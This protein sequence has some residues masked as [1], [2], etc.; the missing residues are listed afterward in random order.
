MLLKDGRQIDPIGRRFRRIV[1][2]R[3]QHVL[4]QAAGVG[5]DA[6]QDTRMKRMEKIAVAQKK[7]DHFRASFEHPAGLRIGTKSETPDRLKHP[8]RALPR[9]WSSSLLELLPLQ[10][11]FSSPSRRAFGSRGNVL[12]PFPCASLAHHK[13]DNSRHAAGWRPCVL[14]KKSK[15]WSGEVNF[16][17]LDLTGAFCSVR[18]WNQFQPVWSSLEASG[19]CD[20]KTVWFLFRL[21]SYVCSAC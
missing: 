14:G 11:G 8:R 15:K 12:D 16:K 10:L 3:E 13:H 20:G 19:G 9:E 7:A 21:H 18:V 6:L 4:L 5:F 2:C 1:Q 17:I